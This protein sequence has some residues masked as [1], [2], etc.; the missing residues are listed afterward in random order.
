ME[1]YGLLTPIEPTK[2]RYNN[3]VVW[4]FKCDCGEIV[5]RSL[6]AVKRNVKLGYTVSCGNH[7]T[8]HKSK[9]S[10]KNAK[11]MSF[12]GGNI[13][14]IKKIEPNVNNKLGV[15]GVSYDK[16]RDK[17]VAQIA[18]KK[19]HYSLGR[20]DTLEEAKVAY[21]KKKKELIEEFEKN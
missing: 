1:K 12:E 21:D 15:K 4:E 9:A 8:E 20:F 7:T 13:H 3:E 10:A 19:K 18:Y 5:Y 2:E 16:K 6:A 11:A 17:Y 14:L